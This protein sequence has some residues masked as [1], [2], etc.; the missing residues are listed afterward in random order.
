MAA[1]LEI[2]AGP[3]TLWYGPVGEAVPATD[4]TPAGN[5]T[6]IGASGASNYM[7][8]G[9]VVAP[10]QTIEPWR[11][12]GES[13]PVKLYRTEEDLIV[14]VTIADLTLEM[15]AIA[16]AANTVTIDAGPPAIRTLGMYRTP[17]E[18]NQIAL[19][20]RG[21][22]PYAA[23][24]NMNWQIPVCSYVGSF[25]MNF[26]KSPPAGVLME[27]QAIVDPTAATA[28]VKFGTLV[29]QTA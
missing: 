5:W 1:P 14:R 12:L 15:V 7:E 21:A 19:L 3:L 17:G 8:D 16:F 28:D 11:P 29:A 10:S 26:Q 25:E 6:Q 23:A 27:F 18:V 24:V 13:G 2:I 22:S 4:V 9:V 20:V